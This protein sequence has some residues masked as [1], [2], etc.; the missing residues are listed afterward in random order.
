M[1]PGQPRVLLVVADDFGI[2]PAT[3]AGILHLAGKGVV[4]GTVL[5]VN[6]PYAEEAVGLWNRAGRAVDLGWHP[7]LTLDGPVLSPGHVPSLV[8]AD[9]KFYPLPHFSAAGRWAGWRRARSKRS[10]ERSFCASAS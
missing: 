9:G 4:T 6:S 8:D 3:T 7:N 5:L 1:A 10:S 2:G